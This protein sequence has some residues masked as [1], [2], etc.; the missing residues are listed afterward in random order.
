MKLRHVSLV[1]AMLS[2]GSAPI[3]AQAPRYLP[4]RDTL[5]FT[6]RNPFHMFFVRGT[7]TLGNQVVARTMTRQV[8]RAH[9]DSLDVDIVNRD[10]DFQR[11]DTTHRIRVAPNGREL[12][13]GGQSPR[14]LPYSHMPLP[15][16]PLR[17][18]MEWRDSSVI[19]RDSNGFAT[20]YEWIMT[21][22]VRRA[23]D[24]LGSS[25]V[26]VVADGRYRMRAQ[27]GDTAGKR[28]W[29]DVQG[30]D[31]ETF[32]FDIGRGRQISR[33]WDMKLRGW[34]GGRLLG[35]SVE[36]ADSV[37]AGLDSKTFNRLL[38]AE[39]RDIVGYRQQGRDTSITLTVPDGGI[40]AIHVVDRAP[41]SVVSTHVRADGDVTFERAVYGRG[42]LVRYERAWSDSAF[43]GYRERLTRA[44]DSIVV[45]RSD[46]LRRAY[47]APVARVGAG[48]V[49]REELLAPL[50]TRLPSDSARI[51][52]AVFRPLF[53]RFDIADV[54][55]RRL[56]RGWL[57]R[58]D[59]RHAEQPD[60]W[61]IGE[62][63]DL[64]FIEAQ[65]DERTR[66]VP[67]QPP[68]QKELEAITEAI[69]A[70]GR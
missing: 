47:H 51:T 3:S 9:A 56:T 10:L 15:S 7:D 68:R 49:G 16:T 1:V 18:G 39:E 53:R 30:P 28:Q 32:L 69:R 70:P 44:G 12:D 31:H 46:G 35:D 25:V 43:R 65:S 21:Y 37:P 19:A 63:G 42:A 45:Q 55:R 26:D 54:T 34:G 6:S 8:W 64:L 36:R 22:R 67:T 62:D 41:D 60:V 23:F 58:L 50:L 4:Q 14:G 11:K 29:I 57:L 33:T 2:I 52:I 24:T 61:L 5:V 13:R 20:R 66:R 40:A 17:A 27:F 48:D 38:S 59:W